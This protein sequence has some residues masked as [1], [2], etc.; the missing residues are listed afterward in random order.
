VAAA[1]RGGRHSCKNGA[2]SKRSRACCNS[3]ATQAPAQHCERGRFPVFFVFLARPNSSTGLSYI[4]LPI[5]LSMDL[6][7]D[8]S[9]YI[10]IGSIYIHI[11]GSIYGSIYIHMYRIY[12]YTYI[13]IYLWIYLYTYISDLSI[14]IYMDLSMDLSIYIYI[15]SSTVSSTE[16]SDLISRINPEWVHTPKM[17]TSA[18]WGTR[19]KLVTL[20]GPRKLT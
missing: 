17:C 9:I 1:A 20:K 19:L 14:Y 8:L 16:T 6:S 18:P 7:M 11:H 13:W 5:Q 12:L 4:Y 10:Y 3:V 15:T 2:G